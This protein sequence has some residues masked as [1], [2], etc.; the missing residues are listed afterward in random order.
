M[1][2]HIT[3]SVNETQIHIHKGMTVK[4]ALIA[5]DQALYEAAMKGDVSLEDAGGFQIGLEGALEDG[6]KIV[7][8][9]RSR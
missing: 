9:F 3:V 8:K 7:A 1:K 4:H 6:A 5:C 2:T